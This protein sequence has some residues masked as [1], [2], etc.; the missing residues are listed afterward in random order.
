MA[1][2]RSVKEGKKRRGVGMGGKKSSADGNIH[3][4]RW[5]VIVRQLVNTK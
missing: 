1:E 4:W 2:F 5:L 3:D